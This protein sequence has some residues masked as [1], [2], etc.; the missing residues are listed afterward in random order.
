MDHGNAEKRG[1]RRV[2]RKE[3]AKILAT[4]PGNVRYMQQRQHL[5]GEK[6]SRGHY[7]FDR[8]EV[9]ELARKRGLQLKPQGELAA[10]VFAMLRAGRSF[11]DIVIDTAQEPDTI[12]VLRKEYLAGFR[13]DEAEKSSEERSRREHEDQMRAMDQELERRR[14]N[15][16][17]DDIPPSSDDREAGE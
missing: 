12:R 11:A 3:A 1:R 6:D 15:I 17:A 5:R 8:R 10:R 7:W 16:L 9:E 2:T 13:S 4:S 14:R